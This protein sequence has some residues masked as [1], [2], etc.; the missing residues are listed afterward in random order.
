MSKFKGLLDASRARGGDEPGEETSPQEPA[1][2]DKEKTGK[3]SNPDFVQISAYIRK[4]TKRQA[5]TLLIDSEEDLSD[6]IE[7]LLAEWIKSRT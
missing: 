6:V 3:T 1:K 5:R 4:E 7:K 2:K